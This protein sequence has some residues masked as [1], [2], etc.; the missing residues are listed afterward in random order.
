MISSKESVFHEKELLSLK[1]TAS[2]KRNGLQ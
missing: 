2:A 1:E